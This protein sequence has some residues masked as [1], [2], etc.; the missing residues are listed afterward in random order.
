MKR[1]R[2]VTAVAVVAC[3]AVGVAALGEAQVAPERATAF[4][5][6]GSPV[7]LPGTQISLRGAAAPD[8]IGAVEVIGQ[9][10]RARE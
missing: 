10:Q 3:G 1:G 7:A 2:M 4:P 9:H 8:R 5:M 6:P